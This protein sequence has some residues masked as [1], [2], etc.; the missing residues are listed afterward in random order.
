MPDSGTVLVMPAAVTVRLPVRVPAAVGVNVTLTVQDA[1]AAMLL[2]QVLVWLKS[3][4]IAIV[5]TGAA[6]VPLLVTV[7]AW[8]AL[9]APVAT[10]PKPSALGLIEMLRAVVRQVRRERRHGACAAGG[11]RR[12][13]R[14]C[15]RRR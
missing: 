3:P 5:V 15:R 9:D 6:A 2:P 14:S 1:P 7:T 4:V 13:C 12:R 8:A 11:R 10:E